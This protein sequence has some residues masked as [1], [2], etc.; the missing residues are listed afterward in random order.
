MDLCSTLRSTLGASDTLIGDAVNL[1]PLPGGEADAEAANAIVNAAVNSVAMLF[2]FIIWVADLCGVPVGR[3]SRRTLNTAFI[4][5]YTCPCANPWK[6]SDF[7][8]RV[9]LY[10]KAVPGIFGRRLV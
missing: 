5:S 4:S 8:S 6:K 2:V 7:F 9:S 1:V 10:K 3:V